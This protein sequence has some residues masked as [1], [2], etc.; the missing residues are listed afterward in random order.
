[1]ARG[2][3]V[4]LVGPSQRQYAH[5]LID[6]APD[7]YVMKLG[8]ETRSDIQNCKLWPMLQDLQR[9]VPEYATFSLDDMK[10]RFLN[11]LGLELRFLPQLEG[12]GIFPVGLSS[13]KL[14]KAQF[15]G[16][17]EL[18]YMVGAKH[19]VRWSEERDLG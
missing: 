16:L 9:Q 5:R 14:T 15:A 7:N 8:E 12:A 17:I 19:G 10:L 1:M 2:Q 6:E 3:S 11:A 13:S 4:R 18:I